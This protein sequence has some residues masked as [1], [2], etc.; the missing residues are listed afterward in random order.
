LDFYFLTFIIL[1]TCS[2]INFSN[3]LNPLLQKIAIF[4]IAKLLIAK[5][6]IASFAFHLDLTGISLLCSQD[7]GQ[8]P[9][10]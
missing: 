3:V 5:I 1:L 9:G 8:L 4:S 7:F 10:K 6:N 2:S